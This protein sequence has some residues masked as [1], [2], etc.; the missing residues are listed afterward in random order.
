MFDA[1]LIELLR[2]TIATCFQQHADVLRS[3]IVVFDYYGGLNDAPG[4]QKGMW[5]GPY[6]PVTTADGIVGSA[7]NLL[8][9]FHVVLDRAGQLIAQLEATLIQR[10]TQLLQQGTE[11]A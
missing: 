9:T 8:E 6:G 11:H 7:K 3:V 5:L 10:Q 2:P 4:L 1:H